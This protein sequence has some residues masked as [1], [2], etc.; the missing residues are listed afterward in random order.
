MM[1]SPLVNVEADPLED[2]VTT[3]VARPVTYRPFETLSLIDDAVAATV[4]ASNPFP[5]P[6]S[7]AAPAHHIVSVS[8][9]SSPL[10]LNLSAGT[11]A[12]WT[13]STMES[14]SESDDRASN[15]G[16]RL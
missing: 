6:E 8:E 1:W 12:Q 4:T 3:V 16:V 13:L 14:P 7:S 2:A 15:E 5:S 9:L 10:N 11:G